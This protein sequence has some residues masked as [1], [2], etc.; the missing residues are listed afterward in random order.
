MTSADDLGG[1]LT[2]E[3]S[4]DQSTSTAPLSCMQRRS[5]NKR[6]VSLKSDPIHDTGISV[7]QVSLH[8]LPELLSLKSTQRHDCDTWAGLVAK[9]GLQGTVPGNQGVAGDSR[10][11]PGHC[12]LRDRDRG[13][14]EE[15]EEAEAVI[16]SS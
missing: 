13:L 10:R 16:H 1:E 9:E 15:V 6:E 14:T 2:L 12:R 8:S 5:Y 3:P 4:H 7:M 11:H